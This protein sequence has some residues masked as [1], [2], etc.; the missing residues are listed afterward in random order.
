M[1]S[2]RSSPDACDHPT[3]YTDLPD[4]T[5]AR[6]GDGPTQY[7]AVGIAVSA[8]CAAMLALQ[9]LWWRQGRPWYEAK[10]EESGSGRLP[11]G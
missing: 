10:L 1:R 3:S 7:L 5:G 11:D 2:P 8:L 9:L 4:I 6:V